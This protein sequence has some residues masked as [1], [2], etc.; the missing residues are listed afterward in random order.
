MSITHRTQSLANWGSAWIMSNSQVTKVNCTTCWC[1]L[2]INWEHISHV[3]TLFYSF[4]SFFFR[5]PS[6]LSFNN[7]KTRA[8]I[9]LVQIAIVGLSLFPNL[10]TAQQQVSDSRS[11][12]STIVSNNAI[13]AVGGEETVRH[14]FIHSIYYT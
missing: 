9:S 11:F 2:F 13:Y 5:N 10:S 1:Y 14:L 3:S 12:F 7:M 8:G 4:S 6:L